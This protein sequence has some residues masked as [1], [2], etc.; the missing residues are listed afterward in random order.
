MS[1]EF[2][3][4]VAKA[5]AAHLNETRKEEG[6]KPIKKEP[7]TLLANHV[8][9]SEVFKYTPEPGDF[10]VQ[11]LDT[12]T[13]TAIARLIP[14]CESNYIVQKEAAALLVAG[15]M[16]GDKTLIT[17]PTGSGKS[18][19]V[20]H[21][22]AKLNR[23]LIRI[24]MSGDVES[25]ALFGTLVVRGGATVW[26]DGA[27]TEAVKY[28]AVCLVDEWEL[29][30]A[31]I[32]MGMQNLL[33][34][35]GYLYLKEKPGTSEDRMITPHANFR[36]IFAGNTVGQGDT[37][38]AFSGVGIQNTATIDRFTNTIRLG[39]LEQKHE[40]DIIT[41]KSNVGRNTATDMVR[42]ASLVRAAY[43]Q[44]RLGLTISPRTLINWAR[45]QQ[46][47]STQY[48][49]QVCYLDKLTPDD[50]KSVLNYLLRYLAKMATHYGKAALAT[51]INNAPD[52]EELD[53]GMQGKYNH[54]DCPNGVDNRQRLYI[55][56][57]DGAYLWHCHNCGDS[58]YYRQIETVSRIRSATATPAVA[59]RTLPSYEGLTTEVEYDKFRIEGQLW[60]GQYEFNSD[61]CRRFGIKEIEDG[62]VLPVMASSGVAGYQVRRYN[63]TP[64]YLTY[65]KQHYSYINNI[66][67]KPLVIV[68]DLLSS[69]KLSYAG[70]P[71]LCLLGT[72]L[73]ASA[74]QVVRKYRKL[75]VVMWLDDDLAG[76]V[77]AKK[78]FK[79]LAPVAP[80]MAAIFNQQPKELGLDVLIDMEI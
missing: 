64:K 27:I 13:D 8:R 29:M 68:E 74:L 66:G 67:T 23:P 36:L 21:V 79:E 56:N 28:G 4:R 71:T 38:G 58:G 24:N 65:S 70:Y 60:L 1:D 7:H 25:A 30:P 61:M 5:I 73:D 57:V 37:T 39:Y 77:A 62:I 69:Y 16:D 44:G 75:H 11:V 19:L 20:K 43:Q 45:K 48:A 53:E 55:K 40:I 34:D 42:F 78:L 51:L 54:A 9:F 41:S 47:Y 35:G 32:A 63:K 76:Q 26:E 12:P 22:C 50:S 10:G 52:F 49:L 31:E 18:S 2:N 14:T 6:T 80:N 17:G 59:S 72:K 3:S 15:V 33:E 46:R